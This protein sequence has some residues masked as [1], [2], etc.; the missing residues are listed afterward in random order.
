[1]SNKTSN[2]S[3][4]KVFRLA[5]IRR[6]INTTFQSPALKAALLTE[7]NEMGKD[8]ALVVV[9]VERVKPMTIPPVQAV[10]PQPN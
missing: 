4:N 3:S 10:A 1:M 2:K 7:L 6:K 9:M 8:A 5:H